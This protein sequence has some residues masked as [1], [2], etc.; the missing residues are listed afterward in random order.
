MKRKKALQ[1]KKQLKRR[2]KHLLNDLDEDLRLVKHPIE[3]TEPTT[4]RPAP[5]DEIKPAR[6]R[7]RQI[8]K[9][10]QKARAKSTS[11]VPTRIGTTH[12]LDT[13]VSASVK[14]IKKRILLDEKEEKPKKKASKKKTSKKE[15]AKK[16]KAKA[17]ARSKK[18]KPDENIPDE[19]VADSFA[20]AIENVR[21]LCKYYQSEID[22]QTSENANY[23]LQYFNAT[24][25][26]LGVESVG[27]SLLTMTSDYIENCRFVI[28]SSTQAQLESRTMGFINL[29]TYLADSPEDYFTIQR[30]FDIDDSNYDEI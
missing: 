28:W 20:I 29:I 19:E 5:I 1:Q 18:K 16:K 27:K 25:T 23:L 24:V 17:Q 21:N 12:K 15:R 6:Q 13:S 30:S 10:K 9:A 11:Q 7:T 8:E 4:K 2:Q 3:E 26:R 22:K 14:P